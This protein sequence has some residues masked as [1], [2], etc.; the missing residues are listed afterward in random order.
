MSE[1]VSTQFAVFRKRG[2][3]LVGGPWF[4]RGLAVWWLADN[5][6]HLNRYEIRT[7]EVRRTD[8]GLVYGEWGFD[9]HS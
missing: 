2:N 4:Y 3:K 5:T 6:T 7:R 8:Q 9:A 1:Y